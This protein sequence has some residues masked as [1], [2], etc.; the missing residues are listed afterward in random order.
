MQ[1]E[2][3]KQRSHHQ[4]ASACVGPRVCTL[5]AELG[6]R[7]EQIME[8][9]V[10]LAEAQG[11]IK[12]LEQGRRQEHESCRL[13]TEAVRGS[14]QEAQLSATLASMLD[15]VGIAR[16]ACGVASWASLG[17]RGASLLLRLN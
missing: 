7:D 5:Q 17:C 12:G 15:K 13:A 3:G 2:L 14:Q 10:Q 11:M 6:N 8:L 4:K 9:R 16:T 1:Q